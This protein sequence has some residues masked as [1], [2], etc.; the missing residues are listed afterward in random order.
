MSNR[1]DNLLIVGGGTAG[2]LT[3]AVLAKQLRSSSAD[4]VKVT[5]VESPNIPILGVGEGTWPNLRATLKKIGVDEGEFMRECDA[6]FKQGAKFVNWMKTGEA[7][8]SYYHP[9]N[10]VSHASYDFNLGPYW[11]LAD[12]S[13]PSY[14]RSVS[15]QSTL[16][17]LGLAPKKI[18]TPGFVGLQE[19]SYHLN[20]NKFAAFL[21]KHCV[22]KL[23]V[24]HKVAN[25]C[26]VNQDADDFI[27]SVETDDDRVGTLAADFFVDS[28]GG[29]ALLIEKT[30]GIGWQDVGDVL[31]NDT[32]IAMQVPYND[33]DCAIATH[34]IS[35]AQEAGW[36]WDIGLHNRRGVGYVY[37]SKHTS[38]ERAEEVL[39]NH[40]GEE[41]EGLE[42]RKIPMRLGYREKFWHKNCV[43]IGMSAAFVE[44]LE[45]SAIYL[46]DAAANMIADQFPRSRQNMQYVE[47]KFNNNFTMRVERSI[48]FIKLHYCISNRRDTDYWIDN[49][50]EKTIPE[51]L[52]RRLAHWKTHPPTKFDFD[53]AFEP[54][55][56]DSY[57]FVLY[58]M[59]FDTDLNWNASAFPDHDHA[60]IHFDNVVK[61][62]AL[63]TGELPKQRDLIEK[64]YRYGFSK[65]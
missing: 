49:C 14:D 58:G 3:A 19:Y 33:P 64:V 56:L 6:T 28:T 52:K 61:L 1:V 40:V 16:C 51:T 46:F 30:Y 42:A 34:T 18:T 9:L 4:G 31:L 11:L 48:D 44:P 59:G 47:D 38:D 60:R 37:S 5:L 27:V 45:A 41:S 17:D 26:G 7:E 15:S 39:R 8:H 32:A 62:T 21:Q 57:L 22:E 13:K 36:T 25:V 50:D 65:V 43:A 24:S 29:A 35:T 54:F 63:L 20:A 55:I 53:Y 23:G 10:T 2:W 12:G